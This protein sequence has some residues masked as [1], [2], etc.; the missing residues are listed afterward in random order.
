MHLSLDLTAIDRERALR[1]WLV[2]HDLDMH[3][4]A[5]SMRVAHSTVTRLVKRERA[6][7]R[8]IEQLRGL[9]IPTELLPKPK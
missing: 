7:R 3:T 4:I 6:S 2:Y 1:A 9:G 5:S 8:R